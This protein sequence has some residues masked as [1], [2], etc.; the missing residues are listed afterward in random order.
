MAIKLLQTHDEKFVRGAFGVGDVIRCVNPYWGEPSYTVLYF[1]LHGVSC[2]R[3]GSKHGPA[4]ERSG[5]VESIGWGEFISEDMEHF[6]YSKCP[7]PM[8]IWLWIVG[9]TL[10]RLSQMARVAQARIDKRI[11]ELHK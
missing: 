2:V 4:W 3:N 1:G 9:N 11:D 7:I 8:R 5:T 6:T 10:G